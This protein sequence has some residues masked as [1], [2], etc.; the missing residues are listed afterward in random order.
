MRRR[1]IGLLAALLFVAGAVPHAAAQDLKERGIGVVLMHGKWSAPDDRGLY[2]LSH[3]LQGAGVLLET[4]T[5]PWSR[6]RNYDAGYDDALKEIDQ[7]VAKLKAKGAQRIVV[8]GHSFGANAA[9]AYGATREG[10]AG[11]LALA[12]GHVPDL[13]RF[14]ELMSADVT[15]ARE[16]AA[17][18]KGAEAFEFTDLNQGRREGKR[19][20]ANIFLSYFDP[21]GLGAMT[22]TAAQLKSGTALLW[23][24]GEKDSLFQ[25][26]KGAIYDRAPAHPKNRYAPVPGGHADTPSEGT[27]IVLEWLKALTD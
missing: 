13:A 20:T 17:A 25:N 14:R 12:P 1:I 23:V 15:R 16:Q 11:L 3:A 21:E 9:L 8:G 22:R 7:A 6:H 27:A 4:P 5:M 24:I 18:G 26:G 2:K 10:V 19:A